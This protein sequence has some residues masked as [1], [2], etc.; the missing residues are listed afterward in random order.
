MINVDVSKLK[1]LGVDEIALR[2]GQKNVVVVL[3]DV[4]RKIP[5]GLVESRRQEEIEKVLKG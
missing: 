2:K 4:D 3:V 1:Q 5:I